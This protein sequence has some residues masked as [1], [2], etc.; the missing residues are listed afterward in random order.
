MKESLTRLASAVALTSLLAACS[1]E[2]TTPPAVTESA[3]KAEIINGSFE[4]DMA[5][6]T[7]PAGNWVLREAQ[8]ATAVSTIEVIES[9]EGVDSYKGTK[10]VKVMVDTLGANNW[11]VEVAYEEL[12]VIGGKTYE[13][14]VWAKGDAG[15]NADFYIQTPEYA[16][17][18]LTTVDF[19]GEWQEI[20]LTA[21][22][23]PVDTLH[24]LAVHFSKEGN[25]GKS[26][27][28]DEFTGVISNVPEVVI[29]DVEYSAVNV[30][31]LKALTDNLTIGVAVPAGAAGNSILISEDRQGVIE[32]HF[33]QLSAENIMKPEALHSVRGEPSFDEA[34]A[35]VSYAKE[36]SMTVHGHVFV[37][38]GQ[39][40]GWMINFD[41]D[42]AAWITM[43]EDH[44]TRI[45]THFEEA[46]NN[47][48]VTSWDVVN[49]AFN[50]N[51]TYRG[52]KAAT[53]ENPNDNSVWYENIGEE[54]LPL[55][56]TAARAA[57]PDADLYYN[58]YNLIHNEV[59]LDAVIA[60]V[61]TFEAG[62]ISGIGFQSHISVGDPSID[63]IK[64]QLQ[65]VVDETNLKVKITE[66]DVRMNNVPDSDT[67]LTYLTSERADEQKQYYHDIVEAYLEVVPADRRGG[68]TVWG[69]IDSDSWLQSWPAPTTE[70][71][72]LF[73]SDYTAK[74]ALQGFADALTEAQ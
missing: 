73:N 34:D 70:W 5:G 66:L 30:T 10:A 44:I 49:E 56:F 57:D 9:E 14:S 17:R 1:E 53:N 54:F 74:P 27:Y 71:P 68:I 48:T 15:T 47:D 18:N 21:K 59:K 62:T 69:A 58:D 16:A 13:F 6:E 55:A 11:D 23:D 33:N 32:K 46:G 43:M 38:H 31:S 20:K 50:E 64:A 24:R 63:T 7:S 29:P 26:F 25:A 67:P 61:N 12:P 39:I 60:M 40:P 8:D 72:L 45:A 42:K 51:G 41:G 37:W 3:V 4:Q 2:S 36:N 19:T 52:S 22:A 35:L 65:K 28:L